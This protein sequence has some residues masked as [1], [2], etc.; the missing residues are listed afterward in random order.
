MRKKIML[1]PWNLHM[2]IVLGSST[3]IHIQI[4]ETIVDEIQLGRFLPGS[5]LPGTR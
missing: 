3:P 2:E 5:V 4:A 1:R